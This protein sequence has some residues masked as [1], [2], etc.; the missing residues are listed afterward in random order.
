M[1]L[2]RVTNDS[3]TPVAQVDFASAKVKERQD[4]QRLLRD[5]IQV[6]DR[7]LYV[8][9]EE[10]GQ[11]DAGNRRIDLLAVGPRRQS[12][13]DR[14]QAHG[15]RRIHGVAGDPVRGDGR[16]YDVRAGGCKLTKHIWRYARTDKDAEQTHARVPGLG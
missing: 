16:Q 5:Q 2:Y 8:I 3:L 14:T 15:A 9:C 12:R 4:L 13:R 10:F 11:W 7:D 6:L 1:A